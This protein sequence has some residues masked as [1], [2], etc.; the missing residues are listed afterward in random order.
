[1]VYFHKDP[2]IEANVL[3]LVMAERRRAANTTD[4]HDA[5][6]GHGYAVRRTG[7]GTVIT[8]LPHGVEVC[9]LPSS[10]AFDTAI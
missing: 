8:T 3:D 9:R 4:W 1:M 7:A 10:P 2:T 6:V 5:L